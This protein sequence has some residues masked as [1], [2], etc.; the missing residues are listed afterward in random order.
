MRNDLQEFN[1]YH[2]PQFPFAVYRVDRLG[3]SPPGRG[4][5]DLHFHTDLQFTRVVKGSLVMQAGGDQHLLRQGEGIFINSNEL[6]ESCELSQDGIYHSVNFQ[7][8]FLS[9]FSGSRLER[10]CV[11]PYLASGALPCLML[12]PRLSWQGEMLAQL[13]LVES[14]EAQLNHSSVAYR[15]SLELTRLWLLLISQAEPPQPPAPAQLRKQQRMRQLVSFIQEHYAEDISVQD[16]ARALYVSPG[17]CGR[18]CRQIL[19]MTPYDYLLRYRVN[20]GAELLAESELSVT[21]IA[22][23]VGFNSSSHFIQLFKKITGQTPKEFRAGRLQEGSH[24]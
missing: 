18:C 15:I 13:E 3:M 20:R 12:S 9:F 10:E 21:E 22:T 11:Q 8:Q 2:D 7:P 24:D 23:R 1:R 17:E 6:H 14:L 19:H 16:M 4:L 5:G